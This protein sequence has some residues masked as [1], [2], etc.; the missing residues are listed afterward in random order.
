MMGAYNADERIHVDYPH[1]FQGSFLKVLKGRPEGA[2]FRDI[3]L[4]GRLVAQDQEK[5]L[6]FMP[7]ERKVKV[8]PNFLPITSS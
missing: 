4:S 2:R 5:S 1:N 7:R 6:W 8:S 3:H